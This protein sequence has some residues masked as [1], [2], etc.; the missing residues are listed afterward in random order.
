M[1]KPMES[2]GKGAYAIE[3]EDEMLNAKKMRIRDSENTIVLALEFTKL[4]L[5]F[6]IW[7]AILFN[8]YN[9]VTILLDTSRTL[10]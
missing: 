9:Q 8:H 7:N 10:I 5:L 6:F 2:K 3:V 1:M 4:L